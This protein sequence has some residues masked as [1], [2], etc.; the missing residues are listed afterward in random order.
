MASIILGAAGSAA[1]AATGLP[2]GARIGSIAGKLAGGIIDSK[3]RSSKLSSIH[4]SRLADLAVQS[5]AYGKMIPI[6]YGMVRIGGNIIWSQPITETIVTTTSSA[7]GG[8]KGGGKVS[9]T[10]SSYSYSVTMAVA[11]CEGEVSNILRIWADAKQLDLS[12]YTIRIYKGSE[13]QTPDS[14]IQAIKGI[15]NTPAYRGLTYVV[16]D[17]FPLADFGNRIPNFSFEVQKK[18]LYAD[19]NNETVEDM[20]TGMVMIP[21]AG[22]F[23]Y[24]TQIDYKVSGAQVGA[25]W[26]QQ[27]NQERINMHN[28][29]GKANALLS[30]DQLE[31]T[32]PNVEWVSVTVAWFGDSMDVASCD[33]TP[34]VEYQAGATT[35]PNTWSVA[36]YTRATAKLITQISGAPQF[37]GTPDDASLLRYLDELKARGYKIMFYPLI[38]MDVSGKP[39][40]GDLTG[41][42]GAVSNFFTKTDGYNDFI[43]HYANLV[44]SKVDAFCIGS[45]LKGLTKL[46][47]TT[48]NYPAVNELVSLAATVK[49]TVGAGVKV[50]Y[51]ADWSEYHHT[52][53]GWYNLDPLWASSN[54]DFIGIDAYFPLTDN[55]TTIYDIDEVKAGWTSGEGYDW[56]YSDVAR[57]T[58]TTL[59]PAMAWKNIAWFW[60]NT[61]VNPNSV[62][63][64]WI[65]NSKK[66]WFT[67]Y[68]FPS[69]DCATNQPNV[70]YD[71]S[72]SGSALPY[73]SKGRVDMRAQRVGIAATEAQWAGSSMVERMFA[74]TWDAR[75]FPY[76][77]DL[78][79]IWNDGGVWKTGHWLQGKLGT[80]NLAAIVLDLAKRSGLQETDIN[81]SRISEM[82]DG[83]VISNQQT[84]RD[85]IEILRK[86]YFFDTVESDNILSCIPRGG[87]VA[88]SVN[89]EDIIPDNGELYK[90]TRTQEIE[91]PKHINVVY[92]NRLANYQTATQ[93]SQR[94][95]TGSNERETM[96]F[97]LVISDQIAKNIAD[98]TLFSDWTERTSYNFDLPIKYAQL[99]PTD[100]ITLN[101]NGV[102]H[103]MRITSTY[104]GTPSMVRISAVSE[105]VANYDFYNKA[106]SSNN[107]LLNENISI[108]QTKLELLDLPL[109]PSDD[110][111]K[112]IIRLAGA[113]LASGWGGAVI[114]RSDDNGANYSRF[115]SIENPAAI[116]TASTVLASASSAVFDEQNIVTVILLGNSQPQSVTELAVLNGANA[117]LL[118]DEIIQF[119]TATLVSEGKYTL[120]GLL[121][122]RLGTEWAISGHVAGERFA[123]LDGALDKQV[124]SNNMIGLLRQYKAVTVGNSL[125]SA[126]AQDFTYNGIALKPYSPV[127]I[128]GTRDSSGNLTINWIRRTRSGGDWRDSVDVPLNEVSELYDVEIL[129]GATII[130]SILG[131]TSPTASYSATEQTTDFGS[132]QASV[133]IK[134]YQIS[135]AVGRGYGGVTSV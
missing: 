47:N 108:P 95:I 93:Y 67:E 60:N 71:P 18:A 63:T 27:G 103:R 31:N 91:L 7:G 11:V 114:Y 28:A 129:N 98:I 3:M 33:I 82:V 113:G 130:R 126:G 120:S 46:T 89:E 94:E 124:I 58:Q 56:Y 90:I 40:R 64:A 123:L 50:S 132:P 97:P 5:S 115:S 6:V 127:H 83:Y 101:L 41:S 48:G 43:T 65:P 86:A 21:A 102:V 49:T 112:S 119:K 38:F 92:L 20:L 117:A 133:S 32:C 17:N 51:A 99:D 70:F 121:R 85:S 19:Y 15:A 23:V 1:G 111:D 122:G 106:G 79:N 110:N 68:G 81:V 37:G 107:I 13:T 45:E 62:A 87:D 134:I 125:T 74:W 29:S 77:P 80:S 131:L 128:T 66:I 75:P 135:A 57:T 53:G 9:Q 73:F 52:D 26:V 78:T 44:A 104:I 39:W 88:M 22:E 84:I 34:G 76:W 109:F 69:V 35:T 100:T 4:G 116:G 59:A 36:G 55:P 30:L 8:G 118:G 54:I 61:H 16:F 2:F 10:S 42:A 72:T 12:Q 25:N 14:L 105:D 96:D 24:D